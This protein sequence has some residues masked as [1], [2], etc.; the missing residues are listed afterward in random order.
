M[1]N[2][3]SIWLQSP[4]LLM[5]RD[6]ILVQVKQKLSLL[7]G[8]FLPILSGVILAASLD[9]YSLN[10]QTLTPSPKVIQT[11]VVD[12]NAAGNSASPVK[13]PS[14]RQ[15]GESDAMQ[16]PPPSPAALMPKPAETAKP[17]VAAPAAPVA[18]PIIAPKNTD[19]YLR[20][21]LG[22]AN[23]ILLGSQPISDV[24]TYGTWASDPNLGNSVLFGIAYGRSYNSYLSL[25]G[26]FRYRSSAEFRSV[27]QNNRTKVTTAMNV[28]FMTMMVSGIF[29]LPEYDTTEYSPYLSISGGGSIVDASKPRIVTETSATSS[30]SSEGKVPDGSLAWI[31]GVGGGIDYK[32]SEV[33]SINLDYRFTNLRFQIEPIQTQSPLDAYTNDF[34]VGLKYRF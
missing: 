27:S 21:N 29:H 18:S 30:S 33:I 15:S 16:P 11:E 19:R 10:A 4:Y 26:D 28:S 9:G 25:E 5:R 17:V 13:L 6:E 24:G 20:A 2:H 12:P 8:S 3:H 23:N 14:A 22:L 1:Q 32:L 7:S 31:W 34:S